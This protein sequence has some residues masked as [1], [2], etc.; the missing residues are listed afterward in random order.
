M[1][2]RVATVVSATETIRRALPRISVCVLALATSLSLPTEVMAVAQ[3][4]GAVAGGA[5]TDR[6]LGGIPATT[7]DK[8]WAV[9]LTGINGVPFCGGSVVAPNK[10]LTAAHCVHDRT[11]GA[12]RPVDSIR[13]IAGRTDLRSEEGAVGTIRDVWVH[14]EHGGHS[15]AHDVAVLTTS[16]PL[17]STTL[18]MVKAGEQAVYQPGVVGTVVGWGRTAE[19]AGPSPLLR[20]A[21][22][23]LVSDAECGR[24]YPEFDER[25]MFCAGLPEGGRDAC[26]GDSGGP[27]VVDG[28]LVGVVSFGAGCGRAQAPGVYTKLSHYAAEIEAHV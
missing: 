3:P 26:R 20:S 8:P 18:P 17:S 10:V 24:A 28:R 11:T 22:I 16:A 14:P 6:V 25:T 21:Q 19:R 12:R 2:G 5:P 13:A 9:A 7:D 4:A 27:F 1:V 23:P 15:R